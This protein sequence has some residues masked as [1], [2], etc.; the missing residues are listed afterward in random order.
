MHAPQ[1]TG[2]SRLSARPLVAPGSAALAPRS[3]SP[4]VLP[5]IHWGL[6]PQRQ[7]DQA[8]WY[9][10]PWQRLMATLRPRELRLT[11]VWLLRLLQQHWETMGTQEELQQ[12]TSLRATLAA[13]GLTQE[14]RD[15]ALGC[16][17]AKVQRA[18]KRNPYDTQLLCAQQLMNGQLVEMATGEGKTLAVAMAAAACALSGAPVHVMTA[19]DY[20]AAR[21]ARLHAPLFVALGLRVAVITGRSTPQQRRAAYSADITYATAREV[22]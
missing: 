7:D 15:Q 10:Q 21:D 2:A 18:L 16:V 1:R 8:A 20:L 13:S 3:V 14:L 12:R 17:A 9:D 5:G 11:Q 6:Q 22:A 19:N 4:W